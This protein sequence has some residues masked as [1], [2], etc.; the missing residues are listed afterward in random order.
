MCDNELTFYS[1]LGALKAYFIEQN[2]HTFTPADD[3]GLL[4]IHPYLSFVILS[5]LL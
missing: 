1:N 5:N 4:V 2:K 3:A